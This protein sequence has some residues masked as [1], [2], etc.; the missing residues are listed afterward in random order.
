MRLALLFLAACIPDPA[1]AG[2]A[3]TPD[4]GPHAD[5][6]LEPD[7]TAGP[8]AAEPDAAEPDA[9][10]AAVI[11]AGLGD[12]SAP[13][14]CP[15]PGAA[16]DSAGD[17]GPDI[18]PPTNC[19]ACVPSNA[20]LCASASCE[21]PPTLDPTDLYAIVVQVNPILPALESIGAFAIAAETAGGTI[22]TC[23]DVYRGL[24]LADRCVNVLDTKSVAVGQTGDTYTVSFGGFA[25]GQRTLFVLFGFTQ[26]G[27]RGA[28]VGV[29]CTAVD[30]GPPVGGQPP[31]FI[32][33]DPMRTI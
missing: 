13:S 8:D 12:S 31:E 28:P 14:Y 10:D 19:E 4:A 27:A 29:S 16:C 7:A 23:D 30:V 32:A 15:P 3:A 5:A 6:S 22:L 9:A 2:D 33:G 17:C 11:D 25:S 18:P 26:I 20:S 24:D 1:P 21:T